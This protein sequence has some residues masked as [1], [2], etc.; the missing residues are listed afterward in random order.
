MATVNLRK[1][2]KINLTKGA[3]VCLT[4][5]AEKGGDMI[6]YAF[7]GANWSCMENG[8]SVDL[9]STILMYDGDKKLVDMVYFGHLVSTDGSTRHSGDDREGDRDGNDGL[10]N[11]VI[12]IDFTKLNP[13]VEYMVSVLNNFTHQSFGKI[14]NIEL[15][16]YTNESGKN[17]DVENV[18]A[19]YKLDN[20]SEYEKSEAIILGHFY[21]HG[22]VWKFSADGIGTT[23]RDI[24]DIAKG[25]GLEVIS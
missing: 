2:A 20:N 24:Y 5:T 15:R 10:D 9:D 13:R 17:N 19:E 18:L 6:R 8:L 1:P 4:K 7:T 22:G 16:I 12:K 25:S 11:E 14:P 21:K 3:K 23:E